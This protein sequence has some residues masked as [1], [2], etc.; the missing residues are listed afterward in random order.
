MRAAW[1]GFL[2]GALAAV[3]CGLVVG[4]LPEPRTEGASSGGSAGTGGA[5]AGGAGAAA[6]A[7]ATGGGSAGA[8]GQAG[9]SAG[10]SGGQAGT[11]GTAG[12]PSC[13]PCDCDDDGS[14]ALACGGDDCDDHDPRVHPGQSGWFD[15]PADNPAIGFDYDCSGQDEREHTQAVQCGALSLANCGTVQGFL[16]SLP[17]CGEAGTWGACKTNVLACEKDPISQKVMRC[18]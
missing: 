9:G 16:D 5:G 15:K 1:P 3:G 12:G 17:A 18:R 11:G 8:A 13:D 2:L 14:L 10:A 6:G 4:D 7:G